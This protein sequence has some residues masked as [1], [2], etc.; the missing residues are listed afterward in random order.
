MKTGDPNRQG[1]W[2]VTYTGKEFYPLDPRAEDIDIRDIAHA[3]SLQTRWMGHCKNFY[4]IASHSL[5]CARVA[6]KM[7][8]EYLQQRVKPS[9]EDV[10]RRVAEWDATVVWAL[11]HD[12]AEAYTGDIIRP[13]KSS[14][15]VR[16]DQD[17]QGVYFMHKF[18]DFEDTLLKLIAERFFNLSWP[19][20]DMVHVIDNRMLVTEAKAN[21]NYMSN[22]HWIHQKPWQDIKPYENDDVL[23][24]Q[25]P[26]T[27]E[28]M[29]LARAT[30]YLGL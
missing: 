15:Y 25:T 17:E 8:E 27:A 11:M 23:L 28:K 30:E 6:E 19:M 10:L 5:A 18:K 12:A 2:F 13:I 7:R 26:E 16:G 24:W 3:L 29:F 1:D 21:T 4:S 9:D 22:T 14:L 20:P